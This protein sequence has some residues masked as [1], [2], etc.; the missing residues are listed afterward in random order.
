MSGRGKRRR[1]TRA[2]N[3]TSAL[4]VAGV[5]L[6]RPRSNRDLPLR[7]LAT[8]EACLRSRTGGKWTGTARPIPSTVAFNWGSGPVRPTTTGDS[9]A[10][11]SH[12]AAFH[13]GGRRRLAGGCPPPE[14]AGG[15]RNLVGVPA[16]G[17]PIELRGINMFRVRGGRV[18]EQWAERHAGPA[19]AGR[20]YPGIAALVRKDRRMAGVQPCEAVRLLSL[21]RTT[22]VQCRP[23]L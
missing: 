17:R 15:G 22:W 14:R 11:E 18:V 10:A 9:P 19:S 13:P 8:N 21:V 20:R 4:A 5:T 6:L 12:G 1:A 16:A 7:V 2:S 3:R 23:H